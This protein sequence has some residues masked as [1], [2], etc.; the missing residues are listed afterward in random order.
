MAT[1]L[2]I[3]HGKDDPLIPAW[4]AQHHHELQPSSR[5]VML[6][7]SHFF[8]MRE[9]SEDF[10]IASEE[11]TAFLDAAEAG[12][13]AERAGMRNETS[14]ANFKA[15]W[16]GGPAVRGQRNWWLLLVVGALLGAF[17]PRTGAVTAGVAGGLLIADVVT[18]LATVVVGAMTRRGESTRPR[19]LGLILLWGIG[20]SIPAALLLVVF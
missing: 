1:P 13:S 7:A 11:M 9:D 15:L 18:G 4:V 16:D 5:L 14:R 20:A 6:D 17:V 8:P 3:V 2:L 10:R 19:K 12:R